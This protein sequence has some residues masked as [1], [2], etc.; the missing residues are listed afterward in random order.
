MNINWLFVR[1]HVKLNIGYPRAA[2]RC[3]VEAAV[4]MLLNLGSRLSDGDDV[5]HLHKQVEATLG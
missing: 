2:V 3:L 1:Q 4:L 5:L